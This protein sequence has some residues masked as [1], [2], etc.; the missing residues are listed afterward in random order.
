MNTTLRF[1]SLSLCVLSLTACGSDDAPSSTADTG[2]AITDTGTPGT[3]TGTP[4]TDTGTPTTDTGSPSD[5]VGDTPAM[6]TCEEY[7]TTVTTNCTGTKNSQYISKD[8]CLNVCKNMTVG[9]AADMA[10][11][12]LGCRLYHAK[13]ASSDAALH[14]PHAG[15]T[16]GKMCGPTRCQ[17]YCKLAW[18]QCEGKSP[19]FTSEAD[20]KMKCPEDKFSATAAGGELDQA[21]GTLNC[22]QYHL[23]AAY[24]SAGAAGTHCGHLTITAAGQPCTP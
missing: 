21:K 23:E 24:T 2:T 19:P 7:C 9:A 1:A 6:P 18:A 4:G 20:C 16:G 14:C 10:G 5:A 13:L 3:D 12:T 8:I 11:D 22:M 17:A 15:M